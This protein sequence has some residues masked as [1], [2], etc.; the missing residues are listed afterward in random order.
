MLA[1]CA[2]A[3]QCLQPPRQKPPYINAGHEQMD[4]VLN[5]AREHTAGRYLVEVPFPPSA[6]IAYETRTLNS[7]LSTQGNETLGG[8]FH[9]ASPGSIFFTP[10]IN[11]FSAGTDNFGI[12]SVLADDLDFASQPLARHLARAQ[13][14]GVHYLIIT[15]PWMKER[16][17]T[18]PAV[19]ARY[20]FG[21]WAVFELRA[22]P[23]SRARAL[24]YRPALVV[25]RLS[26]KERRRG[27]YDF[28]RLAEEQ[29]ADGWFDVLLVHSPV[30]DVDRLQGLEDFGSLVLDTY[31]CRNEELAY[32]R[33][34]AFAQQRRLVLLSSE[35]PLFQ[36]IRNSLSEFPQAVI[37]TRHP[38]QSNEPIRS[39]E[40]EFHYDESAVRNEW[41]AIRAALDTGKVKVPTE[42]INDSYADNRISIM[43]AS[44]R[45]NIRLPVL[46][47]TTYHP[48][49]QRT[50]A[51]PVYAATPFF[52]LTF[53]DHPTVLVYERYW[54]EQAGGLLSAIVLLSIMWLCR[55]RP[56]RA[57]NQMG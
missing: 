16:L 40:P 52:M 12:S 9:E 32:T 42:I 54:Y 37:V 35:S 30:T 13:F 20:D 45:P 14:V 24:N 38:E 26:L 19:G 1:A 34:R 36:R 39:L 11:A 25:S 47:S 4:A 46:L 28:V 41:R 56:G 5:F 23:E 7:Y 51:D 33:L 10:L 50:D 21:P 31:D 18:E 43:P 53:L 29:F 44:P 57:E 3:A 15:S 8:V 55:S 49:W 48:N 2:L 17:A 27:E 22:P 6:N